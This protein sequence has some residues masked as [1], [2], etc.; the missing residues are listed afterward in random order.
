MGCYTHRQARTA[1]GV[2]LD[3]ES[4]THGLRQASP[5]TNRLD[6]E[7]SLDV[8]AQHRDLHRILHTPVK[9]PTGGFT[10]RSIP[11]PIK[12]LNKDHARGRARYNDLLL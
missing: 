7:V 10:P 2:N 11:F 9:N 1:A 12:S 5:M 6:A 4:E 3:L 8:L